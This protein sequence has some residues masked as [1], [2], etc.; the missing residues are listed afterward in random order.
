MLYVRNGRLPAR[1]FAVDVASGKRTLL[2]ELNPRDKVGASGVQEVRLTPDGA[3][4]VFGDIKT[5]H[6]LYQVTGLL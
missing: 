4:Y 1:I 5:L 2:H 3:S 6:D